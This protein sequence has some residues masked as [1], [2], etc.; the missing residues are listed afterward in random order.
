[1]DIYIYI[2]IYTSFPSQLSICLMIVML[3]GRCLTKTY[4]DS[5]LEKYN[6]L[7][8]EFEVSIINKHS[9]PIAN[10]IYILFSR[11]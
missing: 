7:G 4:L 11:L 1:M 6:I 5:I 10:L 9:V 2:Y 3:L 8:K